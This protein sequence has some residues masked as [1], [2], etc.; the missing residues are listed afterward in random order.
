M[1]SS[2]LPFYDQFE[3]LLLTFQSVIMSNK[4]TI[5]IESAI[6]NFVFGIPSPPPGLYSIHYKFFEYFSVDFRQECINKIPY[7]P[8]DLKVLVNHFSIQAIMQLV[9]LVL[10]EKPIFIFCENKYNLCTLVQGL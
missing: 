7:S 2:F 3:S 9:K 5:P 1:I 8:V 10:L 4:L 6:H